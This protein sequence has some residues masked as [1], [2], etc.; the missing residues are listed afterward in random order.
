MRA[1]LNDS[2]GSGLTSKIRVEPMKIEGKN[3]VLHGKSDRKNAKKNGK[4][5]A[6]K[7]GSTADPYCFAWIFLRFRSD[8]PCKCRFF[9]WIF[10]GSTPIFKVRPDSIESFSGGFGR[11]ISFLIL[12]LYLCLVFYF[13]SLYGWL[14]IFI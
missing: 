12:R 7:Y 8:F 11:P 1:P 14:S 4:S 6:K 10:I 5:Q 9:A 13:R 3:R 2:F